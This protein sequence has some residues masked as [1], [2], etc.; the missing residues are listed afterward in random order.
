MGESK[1]PLEL[2]HQASATTTHSSD[3]R[4]D[5]LLVTVNWRLRRLLRYVEA[6]FGRALSFTRAAEICG[7]EKTYFCR[8]FQSQTGIT[9][10]EWLMRMRVERAK[11]LLKEGHR[12]I[13]DVATAVGY[14]DITTFERHFKRCERVSPIRYRKIQRTVGKACETT[15]AAEKYTMA[16]ETQPGHQADNCAT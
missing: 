9:F 16:A 13:A 15:M 5:P 4:W 6:N 2:H 14:E 1:I 8:F 12:S 11:D 10:S 3:Q 7:L